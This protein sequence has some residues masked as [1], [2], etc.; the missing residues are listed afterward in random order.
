MYNQE[1]ILSLMED[2]MIPLIHTPDPMNIYIIPYR[3]L[4]EKIYSL[5]KEWENLVLV[6]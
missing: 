6:L 4:P 3:R 5:A 1:N 2:F